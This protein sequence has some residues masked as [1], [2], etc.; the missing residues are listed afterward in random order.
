MPCKTS[1]CY[2]LGLKRCRWT[3]VLSALDV[4][5]DKVPVTDPVLIPAAREFLQVFRRSAFPGEKPIIALCAKK[6]QPTLAEGVIS[7]CPQGEAL[8][9]MYVPSETI[10]T[11]KN[12]FEAIALL[13][14]VY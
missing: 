6:M 8:Y 2:V 9:F 3:Q 14:F 4:S 12:I 5:E 10:R 7:R 11:K 13:L 1:F